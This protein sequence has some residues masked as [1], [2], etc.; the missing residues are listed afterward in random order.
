MIIVL[1]GRMGSGKSTLAEAIKKATMSTHVFKTS[2]VLDGNTRREKQESGANL[3][4]RTEG[5]WLNQ[6]VFKIAMISGADN[7]VV[8]AARTRAQVQKMRESVRS[9]FHVHLAASPSLSEERRPQEPRDATELDVD[10]LRAIADLVL[11]AEQPLENNLA[12]V[13]ARVSPLAPRRMVDVVVGAQYGSEGKGHICALM[14]QLGHY[15]GLVRVGGAN[16]GHTV[17][18]P[19]TRKPYAFKLLPSGSFHCGS[20]L[21]IAP[22]ACIDVDLLLKEIADVGEGQDPGRFRVD[23]NATVVIDGFKALEAAPGGLRD[24]IGST[25]QGVG[26][27]AAT[28][29]LGRGGD[30]IRLA[31]DVPELAPFLGDFVDDMR[32]VLA[33]GQPI[34]V[35]GTQG[36]GL[37]LY[38]GPYPYV[39]SRDTTASGCLSEAGIGPRFVRDVVMV[40]RSNPIR[41]QSP[42]GGTSGPMQQELSWEDVSKRAGVD[43]D[44]LRERERTTTTHRLR[45]V[46]EMDWSQLARAARL[47]GP[48]QIALTFADYIDASNADAVRMSGLTLKTRDFI[49]E[50]EVV[51]GAPVTM[52]SVGPGKILRY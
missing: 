20:G 27:A 28:R 44:V 11:D 1:S 36:T 38:H 7:L 48:T 26:A 41:V 13:L 51:C 39:T 8:D 17:I 18:N 19:R 2:S 23:R 37:S 45:R 5:D 10:S 15:Q 25:A 6:A 50:V 24:R 16:A 34:M 52:V 42:E 9:L 29:I 35:E 12:R 4:A 43:A 47:N 31:G 30:V 21:V 33:S 3:D 14:A 22:G 32:D 49:R 40:V 46:G